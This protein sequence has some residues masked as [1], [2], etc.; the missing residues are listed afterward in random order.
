[1]LLRLSVILGLKYID[2]EYG[3]IAIPIASKRGKRAVGSLGMDKATLS[4][5]QAANI[6]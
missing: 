3:E 1:M 2:V 5:L 4:T 6:S